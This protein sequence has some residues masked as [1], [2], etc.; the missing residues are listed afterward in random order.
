MARRGPAEAWQR[1][2][3]N[4]KAQ[5]RLRPVWQSAGGAKRGRRAALFGAVVRWCWTALAGKAGAAAPQPAAPRGKRGAQLRR[6]SAGPRW[7]ADMDC[8]ARARQ[9]GGIGQ[10]REA[11]RGLCSVGLGKGS[12]VNGSAALGAAGALLGSA[13]AL[14]CNARAARRRGRVPRGRGDA[15]QRR[16]REGVETQG[17]GCAPS[18]TA[19]AVLS[20]AMAVPGGAWPREAR[21]VRDGVKRGRSLGVHSAAMAERGCAGRGHSLALLGTGMALLGQ[22]PAGATQA[23]DSALQKRGRAER[24]RCPA[25]SYNGGALHRA[26]AARVSRAGWR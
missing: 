5:R 2:H 26:A 17:V 11:M 22:G 7:A 19:G 15:R 8:G 16:Q 6:G 1:W 21:A 12:A 20:H 23:K 14:R 13:W 18:G 25:W 3:R 9:S 24:R 4:G 10:L